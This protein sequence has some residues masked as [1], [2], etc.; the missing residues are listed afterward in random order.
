MRF[1]RD[2]F[3]LAVVSSN[4]IMGSVTGTGLYDYDTQVSVTATA[5]DGYH[6]VQWADGNKNPNRTYT[7]GYANATLTA[8]FAPNTYTITVL[9]DNEE[10]GNVE[11]SGV[12]HY[13]TDYTMTATAL[14]GYHFTGWNDDN[15][16]NPRTNTV[17]IGD[18][19]FTASFA[20]N[21]YLIQVLSANEEMGS[22]TGAGEFDYNTQVKIEALPQTG[23]RFLQWNDGDKQNPRT[24]Q[25]P[26]GG[27]AFTAVFGPADYVITVLS[28][29]AERGTVS[30]G[31][32]FP[33]K[34][35]I[36]IAATAN[37]GYHFVQ[38]NDGDKQNPRTIDV[39]AEDVTYTATFAPNKY[40]INAAAEDPEMGS[41]TGS[42]SYDYK[43]NVTIE[44]VAETGFHFVAWNDNETVN[45][46]VVNVPIGGISLTATFARNPYDITV[47]SANEAYGTV[48]GGGTFL[49]QEEIQI[50]ASA[51]DGYHF[52]AWG[53]GNKNN[54]RTIIVPAENKT[55]T[56]SF[57]PNIYHINAVPADAEMGQVDGSGDY[58]Y[59]TSVA[60]TATANTGYHFT[61][62]LDEVLTPNRQVTV[63]LGDATYTAEFDYNEYTI[64]VLSA[65][66]EM[67]AV[68]G[69]GLYKF[70]SEVAIAA[71]PIEGYHFVAWNDNNEQNPRTITIGAQDETFTA[72]FAPNQYLVS[73]SASVDYMGTVTGSGIYDY[74]SEVIIEAIPNEGYRF[75]GWSDQVFSNPRTINV[76][77]NGIELSAVFAPEEYNITVLSADEKKGTVTGSGQ[78]KFGLEVFIS[79]TATEGYHFVSWNDGNEENPRIVIVSAQDVTYTATFEIN[80]YAITILSAD[81]NAGS[82]TGSGTYDAGT[83]VTISAVPAEGFFFTN[84]SDGSVEN[85]RKIVVT[86]D[87]TLT[88]SFEKIP[89]Y[90]P[91]NLHVDITE[92]DNDTKIEFGWDK[93][94][95]VASY[96]VQ[97]SYNNEQSAPI[98]TTESGLVLLLS[99]IQQ[100]YKIA[101]GTYT[102][103][104]FVI[105]LDANNQP[106]SDWAQ[107]ESFSVTI[108]DVGTEIEEV[109]SD[110]V[111]SKKVL[112]NGRVYILSGEHLYDATGKMVK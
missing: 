42:G 112:I 89:D 5:H 69:T 19:T 51:V 98:P 71:L 26:I 103:E 34:T 28:A 79:A 86:E 8:T 44:A 22:V 110:V 93:I 57:A 47:K 13:A 109:A 66:E 74:N 38:W 15:T 18:K 25:V 58:E 55:F 90:T 81:E 50:A 24:V 100:Q 3:S 80:R 78:Y 97:L 37:E 60:L 54:P 45:P 29:N 96:A 77:L 104:W 95:G 32:T 85:P 6:F 73:L 16:D 20:P 61:R 107:G 56:A 88:A 59:K 87:L 30:G 46:R 48:S 94:D 108:P 31:G 9:S 102:I 1:S 36:E 23:Y 40:I 105:S 84:W 70:K 63:G 17:T 75:V 11:G 35:N 76:P 39:I 111:P 64:T 62:W 33:F 53:D 21:K 12:Y 41:V 49:F 72:T 92:T 67:G 2:Q 27:A 82:V 10:M 91:T 106:L 7:M 68:S 14:P 43:S 99:I 101:A 4:E 83:E 65:N 52:V